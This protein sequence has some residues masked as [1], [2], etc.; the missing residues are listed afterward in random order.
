MQCCDSIHGALCMHIAFH[1]SLVAL[2]SLFLS[3]PCSFLPSFLLRLL[4]LPF[5][6]CRGVEF[7][8][9][10]L[11]FNAHSLSSH[12]PAQLRSQGVHGTFFFFLLSFF[13]SFFFFVCVCVFVTVF[14]T[15]QSNN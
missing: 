14:Y 12:L 11:F 9:L 13:L 15:N 10:L 2:F 1:S 6:F 5:S 3:P 4:L 7:T 8:C